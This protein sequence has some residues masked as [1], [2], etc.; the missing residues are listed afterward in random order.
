[1]RH[2]IKKCLIPHKGNNH[3]PHILRKNGI[4]AM[5]AVS[6]TVF[7]FA[8]TL[9]SHIR[10]GGLAAIFE[11]T[12]VDLT[13]INR[14]ENNSKPLNQ[15]PLLMQAAKLKAED[16]AKKS[17]FSHTS[18]DGLGPQDWLKKA[19]YNFQY[20]GEN[21]AVHFSD[22]D[23]VEKAWMQSSG[24][25][26]NIINPLFTEIG[27]AT[28]TGYYE[29]VETQFVVVFFGKQLPVAASRNTSAN[30]QK[31]T[32]VAAKPATITPIVSPV[33]AESPISTNV[34]PAQVQSQSV[35]EVPV[36]EMQDSKL[37]SSF[38]RLAT[39]PGAAV[40]Y[41]YTFMGIVLLGV[42]L[43]MISS[44][45]NKDQAKDIAYGVAVLALMIG[46]GAVYFSYFASTGIIA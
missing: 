33:P 6:L 14:Q 10:G 19:G 13:N 3:R 23:A 32:A 42:M 31:P 9:S 1:M 41:S 16:M 22:S 2:S 28:A 36:Q 4:L 7:F 38:E 8:I 40:A 45:I 29:G 34:L 26:A 5:I 39:R 20:A 18:P 12:I 25:R 15:N 44:G 27:I 43:L 11:N 30:N 21:L 35:K 46:L 37:T 24:H 17:Y